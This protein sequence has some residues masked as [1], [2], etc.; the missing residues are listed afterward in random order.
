MWPEVYEL[1]TATITPS[2]ST[3]VLYDLATDFEE[4]VELYQTAPTGIEDIV[5]VVVDA[6]LFNVNTTVSTSG[7]ALRIKSWPYSAETAYLTYKAKVATST[8][9][10]TLQRL[11][12]LGT[13]QHL[14]INEAEQKAGDPHVSDFELQKV[15]RAANFAEQDYIDARN[16]F[17][18]SQLKKTGAT[19]GFSYTRRYG[20]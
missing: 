8:T 13:A 18:S 1:K 3:T 5:R 12:A 6:E 15:L 17:A 4:F 11:I 9:D 14:L 2:I 16:S 20:R 7:K 19:R 10:T